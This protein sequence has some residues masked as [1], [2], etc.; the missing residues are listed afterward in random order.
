DP[1]RL[2]QIVVNLVV[3]AIK[4]TEQGK[5][6]LVANIISGDPSLLEIK[7]SDTGVGILDEN[8]SKINDRFF[9]EQ[10]ELSGRYGG[11]GLGLSIVRQLIA[12]F[13]GELQAQS[14]KGKGSE[15]SIRIPVIPSVSQTKG[16][17]GFSEKK[18]PKLN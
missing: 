10:D 16:P 13:G 18:L 1:L 3:N 8:L 14:T 12:L 4:Y 5:V 6:T 7:V 9:R 11:Y 17:S 2:S 15:F